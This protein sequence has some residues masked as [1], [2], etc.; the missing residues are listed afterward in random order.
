LAIG[1]Q[2]DATR[3]QTWEFIKGH[4]DA[5]HAL[6]TPELGGA[7][8]GST[9]AFC[10]AEKRD[11]VQKFF[12]DHKVASADQAMKH[13]VERING[14]IEMRDLQEPNLKKWMAAQPGQ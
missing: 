5:V 10:T 11:D 8:V 4:W 2:I 14:C 9:A 7:L 12:A 13:S 3:D 6:L 1:L